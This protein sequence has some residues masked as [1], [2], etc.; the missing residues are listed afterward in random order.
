MKFEIEQLISYILSESLAFWLSYTIIK[1]AYIYLLYS[2][3]IIHIFQPNIKEELR[4]RGQVQASILSFPPVRSRGTRPPPVSKQLF[5]HPI[6][7]DEI[8]ICTYPLHK[9]GVAEAQL[10]A[11]VWTIIR[12]DW[13]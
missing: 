5:L 13:S 12:K 1:V 4:I 3:F 8:P 6:Y 9:D 11:M 7:T 2:V 10:Q